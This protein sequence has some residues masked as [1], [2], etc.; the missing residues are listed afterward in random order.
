MISRKF[1]LLALMVMPSL[2]ACNSAA[3]EPEHIWAEEV[4]AAPSER[5]L[6]ETALQT[7]GRLG[8]PVGS[9]ADPNAL[10]ITSGW[11]NQLSPFRGKGFRNMVD[12]RMVYEP[13]SANWNV[14]VSVKHQANMALVRPLDPAY[15]EW[16]WRADDELE[17]AI[18]L[19]H[20]IAAFPPREIFDAERNAAGPA[21]H[22]AP[23]FDGDT[24]S[25]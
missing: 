6:W 25:L 3:E 13:E 23:A 11:K 10:T 18:I 2:G 12:L 8:Y 24:G 7:L 9:S 4:V 17:A 22:M 21:S 5:L 20:I 19:Q 16:E 15:A 1:A 14:E